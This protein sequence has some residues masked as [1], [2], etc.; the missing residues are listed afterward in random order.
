M[1]QATVELV[2][3]LIK[4]GYIDIHNLNNR[5]A[6]ATEGVPQGS[7]LSPILCNIYLDEVDKFF[8][9]TISPKYNKGEGRRKIL[10]L[11]YQ[12][13]KITAEDRK[14]LEVYPELGPTI[15]RVK[16]NRWVEAGKSRYDTRDSEHSRVYYI[17]YADDMLIG[18]TG[19]KFQADAIYSE[20]KAFLSGILLNSNE[21][22]SK[23]KHGSEYTKFLG[24]LIK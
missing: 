10:P 4:V 20:L 22:K 18:F 1:D 14:I 5:Q 17:R 8:T 3:K 11:Y 15:K 7:I 21:S 9:N 13:H 16:H 2:G 24:T 6:Y 19:T 23:V 12:E